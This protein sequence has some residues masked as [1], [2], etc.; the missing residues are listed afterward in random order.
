M[1]RLNAAVAICRYFPVSRG[2]LFTVYTFD[3][4]KFTA[5]FFILRK[6]ATKFKSSGSAGPEFFYFL[7]L[8]KEFQFEC[9]YPKLSAYGSM[10]LSQF[11]KDIAC[12]KI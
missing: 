10:P 6:Y 11:V 4:K 5:L 12:Q 2:R 1:P 7:S 9:R 3:A 8:T